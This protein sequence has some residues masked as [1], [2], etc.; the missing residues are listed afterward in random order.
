[1]ITEME[2][3]PSR[4]SV[5]SLILFV[6]K[7]NGKGLQLYVDYRHLNKHT[8]KD[9]T[10]LPIMDELSRKMRACDFITKI[11]MKAGFHLM[12]IA[13]GQEKFTAFR[14]KFRL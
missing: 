2:M 14:T 4:C 13:R 9:K 5:G 10:P 8:K 3:Q 12:R 11:V 1:M 6:P 7:Y